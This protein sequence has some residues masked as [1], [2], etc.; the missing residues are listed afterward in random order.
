M[1]VPAIKSSKRQLWLAA[2]KPP[3]Y[4]VAVIP[5]WVGTAVAFTERGTINSRILLMFTLAAI[6]VLAWVNISN[7]AFDAE[8]GV[9][10]NK[11][12]SLVNLTGN[13]PF[14]FWLGNVFLA[15]GLLGIVAIA[16]LQQDPTVLLIVLLTC[17]LGY[18]YQGPPFRLGYHGVGEI[19]CFVCFGPLAISAAYY[20][21][22]QSWSLAAL[23]ISII[24]GIATS[25]VLF[26]SHFHQLE[27][28]LAVGKRSPIVR[29][30]TA[31]AAEL[32]R[33]VTGSLYFFTSLFAIA[34][35]IPL[36]TLLI[37]VSLP[38]SIQLCRHV[39]KH[40]DQPE[41]VSNCKFI[42]IAVHFSSGIALI[43]GLAIGKFGAM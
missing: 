14:V 1:I 18:S 38:F 26:C 3:M 25:L 34:G 43:A 23:A 24:V 4:S 30:G 7:D 36:W 19:I 40:H 10:R 21:Q 8:T 13:Q 15:I 37:F 11:A 5:I 39:G 35:L 22:T 42:A 6:S 29:L 17:A 31:K 2:I 27:D 28:D 9:D 33:W 20:S 16:W 32:L 41:L 12:H